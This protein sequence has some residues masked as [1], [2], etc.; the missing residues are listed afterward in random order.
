MQ[1]HGA[2]NTNETSN[3]FATLPTQPSPSFPILLE[4]FGDHPF[5]QELLV[6]KNN[7]FLPATYGK[8]QE[9]T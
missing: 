8:A 3:S 4:Q 6:P 9:T 2:G 7:G 5:N 1:S